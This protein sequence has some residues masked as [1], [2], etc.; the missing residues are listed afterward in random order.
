[1]GYFPQK[2]EPPHREGE[3]GKTGHYEC[4]IVKSAIDNRAGRGRGIVCITRKITVGVRTALVF[5]TVN[6]YPVFWVRIGSGF[7]QA[8]IVPDKRKKMKKFHV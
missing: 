8:E 7:R 3:R 4:G 6:F 2:I 5:S 1:L